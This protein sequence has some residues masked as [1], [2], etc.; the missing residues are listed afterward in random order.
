MGHS[1]KPPPSNACRYL[2]KTWN[3]LLKFIQGYGLTNPF[4]SMGET[5]NFWTESSRR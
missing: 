3:T 2:N 1:N 4:G 5:A